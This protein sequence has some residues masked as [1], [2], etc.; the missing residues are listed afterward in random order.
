[1]GTLD[2][3]YRTEHKI[4]M[5]AQRE[6]LKKGPPAHPDTDNP[7]M[8]NKIHMDDRIDPHKHGIDVNRT[9]DLV[10]DS[11][12]PEKSAAKLNLAGSFKQAALIAI[13]DMPPEPNGQG[14]K[15]SGWAPV[16][17]DFG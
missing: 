12:N 8:D 4:V 9:A 15:P 11:N 3:D 16:T 6:A 10:G 13:A 17:N 5:A 1:M 2:D 7:K 14:P